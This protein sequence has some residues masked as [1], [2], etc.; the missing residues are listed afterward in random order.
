MES[1]MYNS[2]LLMYATMTRL[3]AWKY[4]DYFVSFSP[5]SVSPSILHLRSDCS[6]EESEDGYVIL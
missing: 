1:H 2:L 5:P 4:Y 6:K 3:V